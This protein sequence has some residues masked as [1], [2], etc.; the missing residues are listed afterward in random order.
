MAAG[1]TKG[2]LALVLGAGGTAGPAGRWYVSA[3]D[4]EGRRRVVFGREDAPQ[5][6]LARAVLASCAV[7]GVYP[8]IREAGMTLVDGGVKSTTHLDT[9]AGYDL[10][11]GVVPMA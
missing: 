5:V 7:P 10:V 4:L 1:E 8:P 2:R 6:P 3:V 11:I 9:A